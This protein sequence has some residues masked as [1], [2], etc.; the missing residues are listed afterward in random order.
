MRGEQ[1]KKCF[2]QIKSQAYQEGDE[3]LLNLWNVAMLNV[4]CNA[5]PDFVL[6]DGFIEHFQVTA[7]NETRKGSKHNIAEKILREITKPYLRKKVRSFCNC[8]R[9]RMQVLTITKC[10]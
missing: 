3:H 2:E 6:P 1:E 8:R 4:D 10:E 9:E 5:F 7:A